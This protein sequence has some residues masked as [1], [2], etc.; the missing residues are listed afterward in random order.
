M[1]TQTL[2]ARLGGSSGIKAIVDDIVAAHL[3]NPVIGARFRPYV[4]AP[5]KVA[6]TKEHLCAFLEAGSGGSKP[7]LGRDMREAHRGM[8]ISE[9]EFVAALDDILKTLDAHGVDAD[10]RKDVLA[11]AYSLKDEVI[12]V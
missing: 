6:V 8:N 1:E 4:S 11:I 12:H 2:F 3:E 7:Y 10:T 9:A 5:E